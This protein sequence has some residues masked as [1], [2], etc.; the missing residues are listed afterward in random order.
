MLDQT[1][2]IELIRRI[3]ARD[4]QALSALY[5]RFGG[6]V[7]GL[8]LRIMQNNTLAEEVT[9][10]TFLKVWNQAHRWDAER[11]MK[12]WLLMI[13]ANRC[14]TALEKR[15]RQPVSSDYVAHL[16]EDESPEAGDLAEELGL[17]LDK[18]R[19]EYRMC[20]VLF[21]QQELSCSQI[22]EILDCPLGTVKFRLSTAVSPPNRRVSS[23]VSRTASV[24][25][26]SS[27]FAALPLTAWRPPCDR[28]LRDRDRRDLSVRGSRP[29]LP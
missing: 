20:F 8:A 24:I 21:Y 16:A 9:Q 6:L 14:R 10:D 11:P 4:Q 29:E 2:E 27:P 17:A 23:R 1:N 25:T 28:A 19:D 13:A 3:N 15:S 7:Y 18:L 5:E 12:P 26:Q 22:G